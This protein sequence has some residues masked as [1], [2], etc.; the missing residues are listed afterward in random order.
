MRLTVWKTVLHPYWKT[1]LQLQK[2]GGL[3]WYPAVTRLSAVLYIPEIL[4][5]P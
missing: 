4:L 2:E 1:E 3:S 5:T